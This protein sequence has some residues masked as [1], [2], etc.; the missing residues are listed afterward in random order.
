MAEDGRI[1]GGIFLLFVGFYVLLQI[2]GNT[3]F[4]GLALLAIGLYLILSKLK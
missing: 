4:F 2:A 1:I 3:R